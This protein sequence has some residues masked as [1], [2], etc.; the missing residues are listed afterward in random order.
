MGVSIQERDNVADIVYRRGRK[1]QILEDPTTVSC[2]PRL[3]NF[4]LD[5]REIW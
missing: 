1:V 5:L 3:T 4:A 2:D